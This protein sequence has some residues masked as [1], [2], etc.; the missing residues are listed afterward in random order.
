MGTNPSNSS[1][2]HQ[3]SIS[4]NNQ[5]AGSSSKS[6]NRNNKSFQQNALH[7]TDVLESRENHIKFR[8][9]LLQLMIHTI[10]PLHDGL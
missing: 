7:K 5:R 1:E 3:L 8:R 9:G 2:E 10:D 4:S 6:D